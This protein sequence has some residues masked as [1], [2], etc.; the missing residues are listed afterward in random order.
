MAQLTD[1]KQLISQSVIGTYSG[2]NVYLRMYAW[3]TNLNSSANTGIISSNLYIYLD[4]PSSAYTFTTN[5]G[6]TCNISGLISVSETLGGQQ[7][8]V[9]KQEKLILA[10][11]Y[12]IT[13]NADGTKS[14]TMTGNVTISNWFSG[15]T[16]VSVTCRTIPRYLT[17]NSLDVSYKSETTIR[18]SWSTSN[19]R[20]WSEYST[21]NG[22]T[23]H[24]TA[25]YSETIASDN[26]SGSF[27]IGGLSPNTT[28]NIKV[29]F[30]R[31]DSQLWTTSSTKSIATYKV[32]T[33]SLKSKTE[34][35]IT[36]NW[37]VDS[38]ADYIWY[39]T[40]NGS[41]WT[42]VGSVNATSGSYTISGLSPNT[43]YNIKT[44]VR[45]KASQT[46]YDT[47]VSTQ[48]TYN[49]PYVTAV[50]TSA[51]TIGNQQTLTL[52]NPLNRSCTIYMK[53]NNTSG[54]QLYSGT[55]TGTSIT[56]TPNASTLYNS[57]PNTSSGNVVYY[58]VYS[59]HIISTKSGTYK[60]KG[61]ETPTFNANNWSY[62]CNLT[63]LT[64]NNQVAINGYS[65]ITISINTDATSNYGAT[66]SKYVISWG[67]ISSQ[68]TTTSGNI[69]GG[70][71]NS[72]I[73]TAYDSRGLSTSTTKTITN[74]P[75]TSINFSSTTER[76]NGVEQGVKLNIDGTFYNNTFGNGG[77]QNTLYSAKYYIS[78]N[79]TTWSSAYPSDNSMKNAITTNGNNFSLNDFSIH[80]NGTSGGFT[81][82][83]QYYVKVEI[84]DAQGLLSTATYTSRITD[85]KVARDTYKDS[86][87]D[88]H[89]GINGL[90]DNDNTFKVNGSAYATKALRIPKNGSAGYGL[91]N[92]SGDSIIRD[93][94]NTNVTV[95]ATGGTLYLGFLNTTAL[96]IL[97]GKETISSD[98]TVQFN[99]GGLTNLVLKRTEGAY[100]CTIQFQNT[101]GALGAIGMTGNAN[102]KLQRWDGSY[103]NSYEIIDRSLV[104][105]KTTKTYT[106]INAN[107]P[108]N[109]TLAYWNGAYSS[110]NASNL[111]YAY[112][113]VIQCKPTNLYNN[114]SGTN[115]T[116]TLSD[117]SANY[118]YLEIFYIDNNS[119]NIN[120]AHSTRIYSPNGKKPNL[121]L[122][123]ASSATQTYIRR[124]LYTISAKTITPT[125]SVS[126]YVFLNSG[127]VSHTGNGNYIKIVRVDGW[128]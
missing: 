111:T 107:I 122:I 41:N 11:D 90:A 71:G 32:P 24:G 43:S 79:G 35:T 61:I 42:A 13:H 73:I 82:G 2:Y 118:S 97:N 67:E 10:K 3:E 22:S 77:I 65:T 68:T 19:A 47:T 55:T 126:G 88:Y 95:D 54:T 8:I 60:I 103:S 127:S 5:D 38:T 89:L 28:Y 113:G 110:S 16:S 109:N 78:T 119:N 9:G 112:Q 70:S 120:E 25:D 27:T 100:A 12:T 6:I 69:T 40:N 63:N 75:Y 106:D 4:A 91:T 52:Y 64:N 116:V 123:E 21:D 33:Q 46:T 17:I 37:S 66:I 94:N 14:G 104:T 1:T 58:C 72:L 53:K 20:D 84:K 23:W 49:Y 50:G 124:T 87:G 62:T 74:V 44:R 26:K 125:T 34:T 31:T 45:R 59:N 56:F 48:T 128:K 99:K 30:R 93:Y 102:G 29:R 121:F 18:M 7:T 105:N 101:N 85:G 114:T 36:M 76:N 81:I 96:N 92:S 83:T 115:G 117:T 39:S 86:N 80:A 98:G 15:S 51:L 108:T 57:I